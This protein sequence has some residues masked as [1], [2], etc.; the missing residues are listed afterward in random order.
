MQ[1]RRAIAPSWGLTPKH[2]PKL[3]ISIALLMILYAVDVWGIPKSIEGI[4]VNKKRYKWNGHKDNK[5]T[6]GRNVSDH[7]RSKDNPS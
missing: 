5:Y 2:V 3:F 4:A 6:K 1:I 7:G